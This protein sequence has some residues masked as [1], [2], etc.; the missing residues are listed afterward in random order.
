MKHTISTPVKETD[1][2]LYQRWFDGGKSTIDELT[3]RHA[4]NLT[5]YINGLIYYRL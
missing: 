4:D 5:L 3:C 2:E 1:K